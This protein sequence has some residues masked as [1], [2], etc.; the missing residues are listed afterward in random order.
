MEKVRAVLVS[1]VGVGLIIGGIVTLSDDRVMCGSQE[2]TSADQICTETT[3]SGSS[4]TRSL[5]ERQDDNKQTGWIMLG[6]GVLM[7]GGGVYFFIGDRRK[8]AAATVAA[9][10]GPAPM[11]VCPPQ[12]F[13]PP[14]QQPYGPPPGR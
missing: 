14:P 5:G 10:A 2:M 11:P 7:I 8:R 1:L 9:P 4:T 3:D 6:I 13:G 12:Q